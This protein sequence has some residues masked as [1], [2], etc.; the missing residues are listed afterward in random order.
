MQEF[1]T[2]ENAAEQKHDIVAASE[3]RRKAK[4]A[5][6]ELEDRSAAADYAESISSM[7][8]PIFLLNVTLV[9]TAAAAAYMESTDRVQR[10][11]STLLKDENSFQPAINT[12]SQE[13]KDIRMRMLQHRTRIRD[14]D[15]AVRTNLGR[16]RYLSNSNPF[17]DWEAKAKRL[18]AIIHIFRTTNSCMR[19][20]DAIN[21]RAFDVRRPL[22]LV[23]V[24]G[25][26]FRVPE[27]LSQ[28]EREFSEVT[29]T[30]NRALAK[31]LDILGG[32]A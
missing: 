19:G 3:A 30:T 13:I 31:T 12:K 25:E 2:K 17:Q 8:W 15:S 7:N 24:Q 16:A 11:R 23:P 21:V 32:A 6:F 26:S 29:T 5:Q 20:L 9:I 18:G 22:D 1:D 4:E 14:L 27:E 10:L 28:F